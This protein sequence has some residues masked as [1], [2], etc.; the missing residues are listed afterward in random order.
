MLPHQHHKVEQPNTPKMH[1]VAYAH[2]FCCC[3]FSDN[4][5]TGVSRFSAARYVTMIE[6]PEIVG[7]ELCKSSSK[8]R[9]S[10]ILATTQLDY[11]TRDVICNHKKPLD[12]G[13]EIPTSSECG[14]RVL[15]IV[16][17][18]RIIFY[19]ATLKPYLRVQVPPDPTILDI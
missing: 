14:S 2:A 15:E 16:V 7:D 4:L 1:F 6:S 18:R 12:Q 19:I 11:E 8:V 17:R 3:W 5:V 10:P 13:L 9:R